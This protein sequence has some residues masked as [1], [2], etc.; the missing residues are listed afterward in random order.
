METLQELDLAGLRLAVVSNKPEEF[1]RSLLEHFG[2]APFL[3]VILGGDSLPQRKPHPE[4]FLQAARTCGS[5][6]AES[7]VVGDGEQDML[8]AQAAGMFA[9][10]LTSGFRASS[11]LIEHG[12]DVLIDSLIELPRLLLREL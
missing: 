8:A 10:G 6:P 7:V 3:R 4:P 5:I 11:V 9:I 12:A 2:V 1:T